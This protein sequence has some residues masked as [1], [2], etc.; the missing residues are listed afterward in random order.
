M[1]RAGGRTLAPIVIGAAG[2]AIALALGFWQLQ[3]LGWKEGL[4]ARVE[5]RL[6]AEPVELPDNVDPV[7]DDL[8]RVAVTGRL[9]RRELHV[10]HSIKRFG[11]GFRVI[12]P[13]EL[14]EGSESAG[15][16][17]MV[18]LGFVPE[19]LKHLSDRT[20]TVRMTKRW[21]VDR[22]T[23]VLAWPDETDS[24]TPEPDEGRNIWF[25]RDV[26]AMAAKL[27]TEPVLLVAETHPDD[28]LV[29]VLPAG[30]GLVNRHVE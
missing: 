29:L 14:G 23:G 25:A 15:R 28:K 11:P 4:I 2:V 3:R 19:R 17:I 24:F 13:M 7:R 16:T 1:A 5:A 6:G 26:A 20:D 9:G 21:F 30:V 10:I 27:G 12:V 8:L 18:D 22:V